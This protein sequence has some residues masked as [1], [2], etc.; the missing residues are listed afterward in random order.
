MPPAV[1]PTEAPGGGDSKPLFANRA[2]GFAKRAA[3]LALPVFPAA[4]GAAILVATAAGAFG[5]QAL[6]P[7]HRL[8]FWTV[9]IGLN[10]ILW[11][12]WFTWSVRAP[13][14]WWRAAALGAIILNLPLPF[15]I[16]LILR[17]FGGA[18]PRQL[19]TTWLH[20]AAI[21]AAIVLVVAAAVGAVRA[22]RPSRPVKGRL[23]RAGFRD[24]GG[25]AAICAEDHYCRVS[26]ADGTNRLVHARFSD[27]VEEV[28]AVE[29]A[30]VRRGQWVACSAVRSIHRERRRWKLVLADGRA[31]AVAPSCLADLRDRGWLTR[32]GT[33]APPTGTAEPN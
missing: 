9:L 21:S 22:R 14:D 31:V 16:A 13:S 28:G 11:I 10:T 26:L 1:A 27:L 8:G 4:A 5:T 18:D 25:V 12:G 3:A 20:A 33:A 17:L 19:G 15:E 2:R 24:A 32:G 7:L 6:P 30:V 29:G 23:W